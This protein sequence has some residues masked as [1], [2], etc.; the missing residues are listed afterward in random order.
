MSTPLLEPAFTLFCSHCLKPWEA[1]R[2]DE[3]SPCCGKPPFQ[4]Q[5]DMLH[6]EPLGQGF[7]TYATC[8]NCTAAGY[9]EQVS[10]LPQ[11]PI[12]GTCYA[13]CRG[14]G[15]TLSAYW[16]HPECETCKS[17]APQEEE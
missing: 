2:L 17:R 7:A 14:C 16:P 6:G 12:G 11:F 10:G 1:A 15:E 9:L 4:R 8:A 5:H 3:Y 13:R